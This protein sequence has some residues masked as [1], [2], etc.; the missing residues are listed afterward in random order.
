VEDH[1]NEPIENL[2]REVIR[3]RIEQVRDSIN[4]AITDL[5]N[6]LAKSTMVDLP[7]V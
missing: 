3:L 6:I 5:K 2:E 4:V 7:Q 1:G